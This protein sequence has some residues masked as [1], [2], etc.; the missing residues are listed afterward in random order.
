[1]KQKVCDVLDELGIKIHPKKGIPPYITR[2]VELAA[3]KCFTNVEDITRDSIMELSKDPRYIT[4]L[5]DVSILYAALST[6]CCW[7]A[8]S[9]ASFALYLRCI[10]SLRRSPASWTTAAG[11]P[12]KLA[13][14]L[15]Q[16]V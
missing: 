15:F 2:L 8:Y 1:M 6:L 16:V 11:F 3:E 9:A 13:M 4:Y 12:V 14:M 10:S 5:D 7:M